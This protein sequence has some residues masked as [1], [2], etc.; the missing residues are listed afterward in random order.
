MIRSLNKQTSAIIELTIA[1]A[2]WG[3]GFVAA[4]WALRGMGPLSITGWRFAIAAVFG[5]GIS[6]LIPSLR[7][8]LKIWSQWKLAF[9][10]GLM[11]SATL[12][13]QTWGLQYTTATKS[14]FITTLYVLMVPLLERFLLKRRLPRFHLV[15]VAIAL[16]GVALIC[17]LQAIWLEAPNLDHLDAATLAKNR[18]N[19]GDLVTFLCA[20]TATLH[21]L[22]F[23]VIARK[24]GSSFTFN[25]IQ[26]VWAGLLPLAFSFVLETPP[27]PSF[28]DFSMVGLL[29]LAFGSTLIAFAFQVRAQ[30]HISPSLVSLL[31]LLESPFSALFAIAFLGEGLRA[32]QWAGAS[33]ILCAAALSSIFTTEAKEA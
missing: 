30:K 15:Y 5:L 23:G 14:A 26:S 20:M 22:W 1:G 33:L 12:C 16:I 8:T 13:L 9:F 2:L 32:V 4:I 18:L 25:N 10:P 31:F 19:I 29:M 21:I 6:V 28:G 27:R 24:I 11:L 7:S 17:D 3:F